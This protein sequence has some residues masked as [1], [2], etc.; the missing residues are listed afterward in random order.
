MKT[1]LKSVHIYQSY[2]KKNLA[3]FFWPT[4]YVSVAN[5]IRTSSKMPLSEEGGMLLNVCDMKNRTVL[6]KSR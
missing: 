6:K 1:L 2:S 4:L 3:Q 5:V